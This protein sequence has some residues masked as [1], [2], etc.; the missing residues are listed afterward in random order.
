M[1]AKEPVRIFQSLNDE[2]LLKTRDKNNNNNNGDG[3]K[4]VTPD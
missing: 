2:L 1:F 4:A 3:K